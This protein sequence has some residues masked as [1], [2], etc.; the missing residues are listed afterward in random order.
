MLQFAGLIDIWQVGADGDRSHTPSQ[1]WSAALQRVQALATRLSGSTRLAT[2]AM[3]PE[4]VARKD[5]AAECLSLTVPPSLPTAAIVDTVATVKRE[6]FAELWAVMPR[7]DAPRDGPAGALAEHVRRII[8]ARQAG[9]TRVFVPQPWRVPGKNAPIEPASELLAL[10][11]LARLLG[12]AAPLGPIDVGRGIHAL[13]FDI[14]DDHAGVL[15]AWAEDPRA[16]PPIIDRPA[17]RDVRRYEMLGTA[18]VAGSNGA[19]RIGDAPVYFTGVDA[20]ALCLRHA[21]H[22]AGDAIAAGDSPVERTLVLTNPLPRPLR[23]RL[24]IAVPAGWQL[25]P[26]TIELELPAHGE[27]RTAVQIAA[28]RLAPAGEQTLR[29]RL[30]PR[31]PQAGDEWSIDATLAVGWPG[32]DVRAFEYAGA[33][34]RRVRLVVTNRGTAPV[35]LRAALIAPGRPREE[36]RFDRLAPRETRHKEYVL[37]AR[38]AGAERLTLTR[39]DNPTLWNYWIGGSGEPVGL[40]GEPRADAGH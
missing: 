28:P 10:R 27:S 36:R 37:A 38:P 22:F 39:L 8:L 18:G 21:A 34:E 26:A 23:G 40:T 25:E 4:L 12:A 7:P 9:A 32:L 3:L 24:R 16:E 19:E 35:S 6:R 31:V 15:V 29:C 2:S 13:L 30:E 20:A 5:R 1:G 33:A 11:A 14:G 17:G